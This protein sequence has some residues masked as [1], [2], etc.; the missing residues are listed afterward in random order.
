MLFA[1]STVM[2][3]TDIAFNSSRLKY[4]S[5]SNRRVRE[6]LS[7]P[8]TFLLPTESFLSDCR[9]VYGR[10]SILKDLQTERRGRAEQE[11]SKNGQAI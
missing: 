1:V 10:I 11:N 6:P 8:L 5:W 2:Q 4:T 9:T 3:N 7:M